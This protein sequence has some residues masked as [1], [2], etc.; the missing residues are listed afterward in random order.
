VWVESSQRIE[1]NDVATGLHEWL[2][3]GCRQIARAERVVQETHLD[4]GTRAFR[5]GLDEAQTRR[6]WV[7]DVGLE[8][9]PM[10]GRPD[11]REH[12][13]EAA[14]TVSVQV[15]CVSVRELEIARA[16]QFSQRDR[17]PDDSVTPERCT[18][19]R[20]GSATPTGLALR[21]R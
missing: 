15:D 1:R 13:F 3:R 10:L 4:P 5:Q 20:A 14:V 9:N 21:L 8:V 16:E 7:Q 11:R 17:R 2:Q 6:V 18:Q 12:R 19:P